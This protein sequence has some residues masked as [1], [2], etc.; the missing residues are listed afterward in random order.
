MSDDQGWHPRLAH[1]EAEAIARHPRLADFEQ[2][3]PDPVAVA[4][5]DLVVGEPLNGEVL[6]ELPVSEVVA[7]EESLPVSV[8]LDLVDEHRPVD[9]AVSG[10]V[11]LAIA[12][13]VEPPNQPSTVRGLLPD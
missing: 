12:V 2:S 4:D 6:S 8:G 5:A 3:R 10:Q 13:D 1:P 11:S 9:S 7:P